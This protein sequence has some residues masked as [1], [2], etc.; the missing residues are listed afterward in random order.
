MYR[1]KGK[2]MLFCAKSKLIHDDNYQ[3]NNVK[4]STK[5]I[6]FK[7]Y[8]EFVPYHVINKKIK[9]VNVGKKLIKRYNL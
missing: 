2:E 6:F 4:N 3:L 7:F 5:L 8:I 1:R 9:I